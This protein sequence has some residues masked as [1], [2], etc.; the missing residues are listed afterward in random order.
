MD[1]GAPFDLANLQSLCRTCHNRKGAEGHSA[2][3][4]RAGRGRPRL[5]EDVEEIAVV[6]Y[7]AC[8]GARETLVMDSRWLRPMLEE[9]GEAHPGAH[10]EAPSDRWWLRAFPPE[11]V[12]LRVPGWPSA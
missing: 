6:E 2:N 5:W 4:R 10:L 11:R 1:G 7:L 8:D 3:W 12:I 9:L